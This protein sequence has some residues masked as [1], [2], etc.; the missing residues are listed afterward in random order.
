MLAPSSMRMSAEDLDEQ[1]WALADQEEITDVEE[2][3]RVLD[4]AVG[5]RA[6]LSADDRVESEV[7]RSDRRQRI[8]P[9]GAM[10]AVGII[11]TL[12]WFG[13]DMIR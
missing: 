13:N 10:V 8:I 6:F 3:N 5:L 12:L 7:R 4:R 2:L 11:A 9:F 1:F